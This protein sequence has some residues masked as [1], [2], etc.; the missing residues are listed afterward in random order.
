[1]SGLSDV[2]E[3]IGFS[4]QNLRKLMIS[5]S[6]TFPI[7]MHSGTVSIWHL[8]DVLLWLEQQQKRV[9]DSAVKD[10]A[11]ANMKINVLK[12]AAFLDI[13]LKTPVQ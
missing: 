12:Q 10:V 6:E 8:F 4:R 13:H 1:M 2:A 9:I 5:H 11:L 3:L 7:P